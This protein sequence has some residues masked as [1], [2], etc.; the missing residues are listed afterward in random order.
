MR[1]ALI[2]ALVLT[3]CAGDDFTLPPLTTST[4]GS[5]T[6][7]S[8][9]T[10]ST[11]VAETDGCVLPFCAPCQA[12]VDC[13]INGE[14]AACSTCAAECPNE[15]DRA[16]CEDMAECLGLGEFSPCECNAGACA[17]GGPSLGELPCYSCAA[18]G[19]CD[20]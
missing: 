2:L 6:G 4:G 9:S 11:T 13:I 12:A 3:A 14:V 8:S 19:S 7:G 10:G 1:T 17:A 15:P 18:C 20:P 5:S 16:G